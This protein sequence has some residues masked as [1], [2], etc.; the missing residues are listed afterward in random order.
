MPSAVSQPRTAV[1]P[2]RNPAGFPSNSSSLTLVLMGLPTGV[3]LWDAWCGNLHLVP[4]IPDDHSL[5][6]TYAG[7]A[8]V[9]SLLTLIV[10]VVAV[11]ASARVQPLPVR[12][13][14]WAFVGALL[15]PAVGSLAALVPWSDPHL[16]GRLWLLVFLGILTGQMVVADFLRSSAAGIPASRF[17][18]AALDCVTPWQRIRHVVLPACAP[19]LWVLGAVNFGGI[20]SSLLLGTALRLGAG[21]FALGSGTTPENLV[22][23]DY[24]FASLTIFFLVPGTIRALTQPFARG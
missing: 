14:W 4:G 18:A 1:L 16:H 8:G 12:G 20:L 24:V 5:L 15:L 13:W 11:D 3:L 6:R 22:T 7:V 10:G 23:A 21:R 9:Y 19:A 17:R 2:G